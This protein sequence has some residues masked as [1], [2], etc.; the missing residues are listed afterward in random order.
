MSTHKDG[1]AAGQIRQMGP[2]E[3][4]KCPEKNEERGCDKKGEYTPLESQ[5]F[6]ED[7]P[8][9]QRPEPQQVDKIRYCRPEAEEDNGED[10]EQEEETAAV[11]RRVLERPVYRC[12][13][14]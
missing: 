3:N 2:F 4:G 9:I 14:Y 1:V 12:G 11:A 7:R 8:I 6:C 5:R 13:H 10:C